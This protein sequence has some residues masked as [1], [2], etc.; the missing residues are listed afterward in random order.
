MIQLICD[1]EKQPF[2][3]TL[4]SAGFDV[5]SKESFML[6]PQERK[7]VSTGLRIVEAQSFDLKELPVKLI[8][9]IQIRP[10]SGLAFKYGITVLNAPSTIDADYRGEIKILLINHG[11]EDFFVQEGD[12]IAQAVCAAVFQAPGLAV[13]SVTRGEGGFGSTGR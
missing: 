10:R 4:N 8:P 6:K 5:M 3:A 13:Q 2:Y 9:E 12:R 11:Q 7:L 1:G